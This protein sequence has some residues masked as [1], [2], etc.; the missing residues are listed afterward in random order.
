[1]ADALDL[2]NTLGLDGLSV[3]LDGCGI[4]TASEH[5]VLPDEDTEFVAGIVED[6]LLPDTT[7]P[8]SGSKDQSPAQL[9]DHTQTYLIIT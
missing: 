8:D 5:E 4:V 1:M 9:Y 3:L 2:R 7:T 6:V